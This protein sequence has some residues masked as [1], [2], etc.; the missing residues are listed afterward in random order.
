MYDIEYRSGLKKTFFFSLYEIAI[1][2]LS[3]SFVFKHLLEIIINIEM[4]FFVLIVLILI[5]NGKKNLNERKNS[6][7]QF[8][9]CSL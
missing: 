5:G 6:K 2:I 4:K 9:F 7:T 8:F 1:N 3:V